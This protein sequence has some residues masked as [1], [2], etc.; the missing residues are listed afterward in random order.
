MAST[1]RGSA[2]RPQLWADRHKQRVAWLGSLTEEVLTY[3]GG[4]VGEECCRGKRSFESH[5]GRVAPGCTGW[6]LQLKP[7]LSVCSLLCHL[8]L[9]F[10]IGKLDSDA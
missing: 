5:D 6:I 7:A 2:P 1:P 8:G 4:C 9:I 3:D 10:K